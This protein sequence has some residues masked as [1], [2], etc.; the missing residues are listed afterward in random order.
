M[1]TKQGSKSSS[2]QPDIQRDSVSNRRVQEEAN[3]LLT[4]IFAG[5]LEHVVTTAFA[6]YREALLLEA[7]AKAIEAQRSEQSST[8]Y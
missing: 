4:E 5:K 6:V 2:K 1:D 3:K 8:G 7:S